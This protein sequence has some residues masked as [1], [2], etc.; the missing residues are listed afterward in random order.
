MTQYLMARI[1]DENVGTKSQ[2]SGSSRY[3]I[4]FGVCRHTTPGGTSCTVFSKELREKDGELSSTSTSLTVTGT[5]SKSVV[6]CG[7]GK[8]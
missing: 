5:G 8:L 7:Y 3:G 2:Q 1:V 4:S 6:P